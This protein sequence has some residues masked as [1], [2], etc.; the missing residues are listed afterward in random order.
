VR[1][2]GGFMIDTIK[3]MAPVTHFIENDTDISTF[4]DKLL[5]PNVELST[6]IV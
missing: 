1:V 2:I 4:K 5:D 3:D 6:L